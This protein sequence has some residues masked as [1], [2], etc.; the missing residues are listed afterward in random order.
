MAE[1][2][3]RAQMQE[4][5]EEFGKKYF[6]KSAAKATETLAERRKKEKEQRE[7]LLREL[8]GIRPATEKIKPENGE[9]NPGA[10]ALSK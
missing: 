6:F 1:Q 9:K 10:K 7:E 5:A 4:S 2:K 3:T 8:Q